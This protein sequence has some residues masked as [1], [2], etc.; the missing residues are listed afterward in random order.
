MRRRKTKLK[1]VL[2]KER[3]K[4]K[5][6]WR[7]KTEKKKKKK[8]DNEK[9]KKELCGRLNEFQDIKEHKKIFKKCQNQYLGVNIFFFLF[10]IVK[11]SIY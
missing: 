1:S 8:E 2:K 4:K 6:C 7:K 9:T 5:S 10:F 3:K 11:K